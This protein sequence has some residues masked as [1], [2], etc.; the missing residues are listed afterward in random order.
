MTLSSGVQHCGIGVMTSVIGR[1]MSTTDRNLRAITVG[2]ALFRAFIGLLL[3]VMPWVVGSGLDGYG[4]TN[5][6]CAVAIV[7]AAT[8]MHRAPWLRWV[9]ASLAMAVLFSPFAFSADDVSAGQVYYAAM[10]GLMLIVSSIVTPAMFHDSERTSASDSSRSDGS[11]TS[12]VNT[13]S[14]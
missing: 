9:Q 3:G 2:L 7:A 11:N 6:G 10:I 8:Q 14:N 13:P 12:N 5:L 4:A 1:A